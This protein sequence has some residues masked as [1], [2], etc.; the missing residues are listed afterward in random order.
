M[1][2]D[3]NFIGVICPLDGGNAVPSIFL[4]DSIPMVQRQAAK[5]PVKGLLHV[6][7]I[8]GQLVDVFLEG[9]ER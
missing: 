6:F 9:E 1:N 5:S 3:V 4:G 2:P 7:D 8:K